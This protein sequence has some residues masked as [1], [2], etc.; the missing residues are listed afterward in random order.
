VRVFKLV[1]GLQQTEVGLTVKEMMRLGHKS[2]RSVY[3]DLS[4]IAEVGYNLQ[5]DP[6]HSDPG[7]E[8]RYRIEEV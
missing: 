4:V 3:Y 1:R 2:R 6:Q 8:V 5:R 7:V